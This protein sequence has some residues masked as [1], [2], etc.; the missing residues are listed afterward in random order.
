MPFVALYAPT[1][2]AVQDAALP[3]YPTLHWHALSDVLPAG[4]MEFDGQET[5]LSP[6]AEYFP[7]SQVVHGPPPGPD[8]PG[9]HGQE[10]AD[11][12]PAGHVVP[13]GEAEQGAE[14]TVAL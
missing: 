4:E 13:A 3:V 5:Q 14:P 11:V 8:V 9:S 1:A 7:T 2:H 6:F 12:A 10:A